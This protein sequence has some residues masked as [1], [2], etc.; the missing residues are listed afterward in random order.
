MGCIYG[1]KQSVPNHKKPDCTRSGNYMKKKPRS[2][3]GSTHC[4]IFQYRNPYVQNYHLRL[5]I[6]NLL[7]YTSFAY[8]AQNSLPPS[9]S[10]RESHP[11]LP[12][13]SN[14][15]I[16]KLSLSL[17]FILFSRSHDCY[18]S[19]LCLCVCVCVS[20]PVHVLLCRS[21]CVC[22]C[23]SVFLYLSLSLSVSRNIHLDAL[24]FVK[25]F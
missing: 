6:Y 12:S 11:F 15:H 16:N 13:L 10:L 24:E 25:F 14:T 22:V 18:L 20:V 4:L 19:G 7:K 21:S 3:R 23:V 17:F 2:R 5:L 9:H 8:L 1:S